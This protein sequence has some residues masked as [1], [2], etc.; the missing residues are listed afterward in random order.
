MT[1][2]KSEKYIIPACGKK[3]LDEG[4][5]PLKKIYK[6]L[7]RLNKAGLVKQQYFSLNKGTENE[8]I[9][10]VQFTTPQRCHRHPKLLANL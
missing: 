9:I 7:V 5:K 8:L 10:Q 6:V 2:T 3:S 1:S 4:L